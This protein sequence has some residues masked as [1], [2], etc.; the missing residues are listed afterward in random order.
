MIIRN[1]SHPERLLEPPVI[2]DVL[3]LGHPA[4][5]VQIDLLQ[6]VPGVLVH[7][8]LGP[9]PKRPYGG[10]VPPLHHV[11]ILVELASFVV[12]TVGDLV[13]DHH[14]DSTVVQ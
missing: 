7:D 12:E 14:T 11:A 13:T 4:V 5:N 2:S 6:F 8:T 1:W 3:P 9:L 10:V